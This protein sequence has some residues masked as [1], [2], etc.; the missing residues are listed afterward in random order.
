MF[1]PISYKQYKMLRNIS[2]N[3]FNRF[4]MSVYT[5]GGQDAVDKMEENIVAEVTE[6]Q[7]LDIILSVKGVTQ[8]TAEQIV[9]AILTEGA[10]GS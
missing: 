5:S 4:F 2:H 8:E 3:D 1:K 7:L 6:E 10:Y 9:D